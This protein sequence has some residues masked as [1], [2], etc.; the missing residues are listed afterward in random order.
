MEEDLILIERIK[1]NKNYLIYVYNKNQDYCLNFVRA[2]NNGRLSED[3]LL[4]IYTHSVAIFYNK[5]TKNDFVLT[6]LI[7]TFLT[8]IFN[9]QVSNAIIEQYNKNKRSINYVD[10]F[11]YISQILYL[12]GED[13]NYNLLPQMLEILGHTEPHCYNILKLFYF[14]AYSINQITSELNYQNNDSTKSQK[15][16]CKKKLENLLFN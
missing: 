6:S 7:S 11:D 3:E 5:I 16:K 8:S 10:N 14:K 1:S 9:I 12:A 15:S 4:S 13:A 2:E